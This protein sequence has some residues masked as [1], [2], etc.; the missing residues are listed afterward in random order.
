MNSY[1]SEKKITQFQEKIFSW[2]KENK[3]K[4]PW[5]ETEEPYKILVSEIMLQQTQ[6]SRVTEKFTE[7]IQKYPNVKSLTRAPKSELLSVWS[8]LGYNRRALWLQEAAQTLIKLKEFP[9]TPQELQKL[10]GIGNYSA[11]SILIFAFNM[12]FATVD[13]N[14]RR[15]LIAERFAT[16]DMSEK[17]LFLIAEQLLPQGKSR[18]WHNALMDYGAIHL[19]VSATGIEPTTKQPKF[20]GSDRERRGQ[21]LKYLL[22]NKKATSKEL[23]NYLKCSKKQLDTILVKMKKDGLIHKSEDNYH[24]E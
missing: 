19:T 16:E 5:R 22:E 9:K 2:W 7:F 8:G 10:K 14:I 15:I 23:I 12:N 21:I 4:F 11:N 17:E 13:T 6:A 3:R 20:K 1:I 24:I 18:D